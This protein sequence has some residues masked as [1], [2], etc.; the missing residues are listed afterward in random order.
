MQVNSSTP[1]R[2]WV[3]GVKDMEVG[4]DQMGYDN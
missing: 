3:E 2:T 4:D 1:P